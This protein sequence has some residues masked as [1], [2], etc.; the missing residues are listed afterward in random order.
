MRE[1]L[2]RLSYFG[3]IIR[4]NIGIS[5]CSGVEY[6]LWFIFGCGCGLQYKKDNVLNCYPNILQLSFRILFYFFKTVLLG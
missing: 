2:T 6:G 4:I 5:F 1:K 3:M